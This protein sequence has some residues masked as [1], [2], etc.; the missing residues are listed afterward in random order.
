MSFDIR[1]LKGGAVLCLQALALLGAST[2]AAH[3]YVDPGTGTML[4][5]LAGAAV[6]GALFYLREFR[7]RFR[8]WFSSRKTQARDAGAGETPE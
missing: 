5:Q 4:L 6:A 3:A 2:S 8:A 7:L 1:L